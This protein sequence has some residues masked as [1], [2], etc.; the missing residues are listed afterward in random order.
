MGYVSNP[1]DSFIRGASASSFI[2]ELSDSTPPFQP[3]IVS[4][5]SNPTSQTGIVNGFAGN[6]KRRKYSGYYN[7]TPS[8]FSTNSP[9]ETNYGRPEI[10]NN[11]Q[12]NYSVMWTGYIYSNSFGDYVIETTSDDSSMV[13][14]GDKAISGYTVENADVNNGGLHGATPKDS[15]P[16]VLRMENGWYPIRIMFGELS[17]AEFMSMRMYKYGTTTDEYL[18][19]AYNGNTPEG[20]VP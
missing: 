8:F 12:D 4:P 13:W 11:S 6:L 10:N 14:I 2:F 16:N 18:S 9:V 15:L 20:F 1:E 17:G 19:F 3:N 7:D 5:S